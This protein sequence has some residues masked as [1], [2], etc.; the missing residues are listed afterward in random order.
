MSF[1]N[2][3]PLRFLSCLLLLFACGQTQ[4]SA[5]PYPA[6]QMDFLNAHPTFSTALE[7]SLKRLFQQDQLAGDFLLGLV[8]ETGLVYSF[9]M[10]T[11]ILAGKP[12]SLSTRSPIYIASHTKSLT[13]T[14]LQQMAEAG[15]VDL[16]QSL[17]HYLPELTLDGSVDLEAI[18]V[19]QLL[20]HTHGLHS[21]RLTWKTAFLGY[22]GGNEELLSDM[23]DDF[24]VDPSHQFRYANTGPILAAIIADKVTGNSWHEEMKQGI[25][26]PL[27][28][29]QTSSRVSD[30]VRTEIR[31]SVTVDQDKQIF[32]S[33]FYK[34]DVTMHAAGGLISTIEDLAKWVRANLNQDPRL[35][36]P[37]GWQAM[38]QLSVPQQ[39]SYFTYPRFGYSLGWDL[40]I[41]QGDTIL[42]R[43]G[44]L[45]GISFHL[46]M[47]PAQKLGMIAVSTDERATTLSH[48]AANYAYNLLLRSAEAPALYREEKARFQENFAQNRQQP[49]PTEAMRL[50]PAPEHD[51]WLG[52][53]HNASGWPEIV[54]EP[55]ATG[56]TM[57][58]G[59]LAGPV[60]QIPGSEQACTAFLGPFNRGFAVE[61]DHLRTGSLV[62]QRSR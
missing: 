39:R 9:A 43:F 16:D 2:L 1:S 14:L 13:G 57:R 20:N 45:A 18:R 40:A 27:D 42:T 24:Q 61:G 49:L 4:P 56:Y 21:T 62:Y 55:S 47:I 6:P 15:K 51:A 33:G 25:F 8:D 30:F 28:M 41:Y 58:W 31:P 7:D 29:Q 36:S 5:S 19:R 37:E 53:Y 44:T 32:Q 17:A 3:H 35:L 48:L 46:S 59:V 50:Q 23:N 12:S 34:E 54:L 11:E 60:Y 22:E 26:A 10:N 38:H 52:V